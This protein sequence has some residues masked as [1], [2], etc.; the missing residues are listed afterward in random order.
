MEHYLQDMVMAAPR[1][2]EYI[3]VGVVCMY[4]CTGV[5]TYTISVTFLYTTR[6][7]GVMQG[8]APCCLLVCGPLHL[9]L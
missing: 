7:L 2:T 1:D 6:M 3:L 4:K 8:L 5:Y 9:L